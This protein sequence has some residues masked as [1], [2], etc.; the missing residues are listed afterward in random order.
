LQ[1]V[2]SPSGYPS[3]NPI[4]AGR[5]ASVKITGKREHGVM[6]DCL[7]LFRRFNP[8]RRLQILP[9]ADIRNLTQSAVDEADLYIA[10]E[11]FSTSYPSFSF[12]NSRPILQGGLY[13]VT[14]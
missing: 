2:C 10:G 8:D 3:K 9:H 13:Y 1:G 12:P 5:P 4:E 11:I 14:I 6:P 7:S